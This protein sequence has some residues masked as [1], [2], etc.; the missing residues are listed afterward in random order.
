MKHSGIWEYQFKVRSFDVDK[1]KNITATSICEYLQEVAGEHSNSLGF[2]YRQFVKK[3][4]VWIL[5]GIRIEV[6][7]TPKWED[8][9]L[10]KSWVVGNNRFIS[11]RD[12]EW[13]D[14]NDNILIKASTNWILFDISKRRPQLVDS[15]NID[16]KMHPERKAILTEERSLKNTYTD[17]DT[18]DYSVLYS[19]LD[20]V[21]HMNNTKYIQ[22]ILNSYSPEFHDNNN[23]KNLDINFK[24][25]AK[26][27]ENLLL[28]T[29]AI[30]E[31]EYFHELKRANDNKI[32]CS[33]Y[34]SWD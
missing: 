22:L 8:E 7:Q 3:Q 5:S 13:S 10:I 11:R 31:K 32:N 24:T 14:S 33:S 12:F 28:Q 17:F 15:M 20:M 25:E 27:N 16:V 19:D 21:G 26:Y 23:L 6:E 34:I 1:N 18:L 4:M 9:I 30:G 2:G 29:K